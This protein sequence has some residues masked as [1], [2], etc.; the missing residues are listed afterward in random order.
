MPIQ[1]I[2]GASVIVLSSVGN[3]ELDL[4]DEVTVNEEVLVTKNPTET[5]VNITDHVV[6]MPVA[7]TLSGRFVDNPIVSVFF[8]PVGALAGIGSF[9]STEGRSVSKWHDLEELK[10]RKERV[11]VVIQQNTYE[12][13]VIQRLS[14]PRGKGDGTSQ[15][16][17]I[18]MVEI[19]TTVNQL[20]SDQAALADEFAHSGAAFEKRGVQPTTEVP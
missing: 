2:L 5:G 1:K 6:N 20:T 8:D 7:I 4:V 14:G 19:I 11:E 12:N 3:I 15:R 16:F 18:E 9:A 17:R 13:M 10:R